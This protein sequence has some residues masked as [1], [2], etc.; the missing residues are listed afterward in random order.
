MAW[1]CLF[2]KVYNT[3]GIRTL[4]GKKILEFIVSSYEYSIKYFAVLI[5]LPRPMI[6]GIPN[7]RDRY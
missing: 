4:S 5:V 2:T 3:T 1:F 7:Q 6:Q